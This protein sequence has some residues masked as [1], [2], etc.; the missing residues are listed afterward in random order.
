MISHLNLLLVQHNTTW[1]FRPPYYTDLQYRTYIYNCCNHICHGFSYDFSF[2]PV[3][4]YLVNV[5]LGVKWNNY[6]K[7][8]FQVNSNQFARR[9]TRLDTSHWVHHKATNL[10]NY[11]ETL[12][13]RNK[14]SMTDNII[15]SKR[16]R[17]LLYFYM[18]SSPLT[19]LLVE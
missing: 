7:T 8:V 4:S 1:H 18:H 13:I 9:N 14:F 11:C 12:F 10:C 19:M 17:V 16:V 3:E 15:S 6:A 2:L 5:K